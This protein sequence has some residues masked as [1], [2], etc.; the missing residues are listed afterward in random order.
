M[1]TGSRWKR[2]RFDIDLVL[3]NTTVHVRPLDIRF[4]RIAVPTAEAT[5]RKY[6]KEREKRFANLGARDPHTLPRNLYLIGGKDKL[7]YIDQHGSEQLLLFGDNSPRLYVA[8]N[9][10]L[11]RG[12]I[13]SY[14]TAERTA[15]PYTIVEFPH[16]FIEF[17][18]FI[19]LTGQMEFD[20]LTTDL[21]VDD[22]YFN[23][24]VEWKDR[25][26][27]TYSSLQQ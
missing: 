17:S 19:K 4:N 7:A 26:N 21:K 16:R 9:Q 15:E 5:R 8:R 6:Q 24:Y 23:R 22:W 14:S 12:N 10:R 13:V 25:I 3:D 1:V 27:E 18:D 2:R 11:S 20:V